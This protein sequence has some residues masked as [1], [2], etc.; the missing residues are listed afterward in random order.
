MYQVID[1]ELPRLEDF[2][3]QGLI[4]DLYAGMT[5]EQAGELAAD[6]LFTL[7]IHTVDHALLTKCS[8]AVMRDQI[9]Q[10][11][12]WIESLSCGSCTTV[13][14]PNGDY[15]GAVIECCRSLGIGTG[16]AVMPRANG[17]S[18]YDIPRIGIYTPS[19][20]VLG[21]KAQWGN[22]LRRFNVN[23]G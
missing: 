13:A 9:E 11:K 14:Y 15:N 18:R 19:L 21:F 3:S 10:N 2:T 4:A 1:D 7:G 22:H 6:P 8:P 16:Y 23:V 17:R 20:A 5:A 12:A